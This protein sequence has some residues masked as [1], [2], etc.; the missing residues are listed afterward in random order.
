MKILNIPN[1]IG[2][3]IDGNGRWAKRR[4]LPR[5]MGHN[6]GVKA[7]KKTINACLDLGVKYL[8]FFVFSTENFKR[9]QEEIDNIFDLLKK[10][11][12][13]DLAEFNEK[14]IKLIVSG[15]LSKLP[16]DLQKS[17]LKSIE[18]TKNNT[19]MVVNMCLNYGGRQE[20]L[21]AC[22]KALKMG[23]DNID[24]QTFKSL[25]YTKDLP[26]LDFVIRTSGEERISN[27]ML[28]DLAYAELYFT[29]TLWPD[30]GKVALIKALKEFCKRERRFGKA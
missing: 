22:N 11:I 20:I 26:E 21:Y 8:S 30:F 9:S 28:F 13:T 14:N 2:F 4:L 1:H 15:D 10:Y 24:E 17:L 5:K 3:I 12:E 19:K 6:A 18:T 29:K 25:L 23:L 27:F 16:F 7:V